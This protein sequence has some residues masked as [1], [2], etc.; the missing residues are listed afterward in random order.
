MRIRFPWHLLAAVATGLVVAA[1]GVAPTVEPGADA[2]AEHFVYKGGNVAATQRGAECELTLR[3]TL[4]P[5][6]VSALRLASDALAKRSC[7]G[8][9]VTLD[10]AD[11]SVG[12]AITVGSMLRNRGFNTRVAPGSTCHTLCLLVFV[13]GSQ[14]EVGTNARLGFSQIPPDEDFGRA[15]CD[16]EL[17]NRQMLNLARYLRAMLPGLTADYMLQQ[18]RATDCRSVRP[19]PASDAVTAGLATKG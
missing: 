7:R 3:G 1:C 9:A 16:T 11:G 19:L 8:K 14:R 15:N 12:A 5:E 13:A 17:D 18:I 6:A 2:K 10:V 4:T